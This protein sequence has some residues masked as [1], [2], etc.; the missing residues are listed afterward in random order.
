MQKF[1]KDRIDFTVLFQAIHQFRLTLNEFFLFN[2]NLSILEL[3]SAFSIEEMIN[4]YPPAKCGSALQASAAV[5]ISS[6]LAGFCLHH[7]AFFWS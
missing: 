6:L 3:E 2:I 5:D 4:N 1:K 7:G